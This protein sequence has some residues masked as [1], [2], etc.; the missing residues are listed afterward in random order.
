MKHIKLF[1]DFV[2]EGSVW[3][4]RDGLGINQ[5]SSK[6]I[7]SEIKKIIKAQNTIEGEDGKILT[8][9]DG[10][11]VFFEVPTV[12]EDVASELGGKTVSKITTKDGL[13]NAASSRGGV[14]VII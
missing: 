9:L 12:G 4:T 11:V 14:M 8:D 1:E 3:K 7:N 13:S 10:N 5:I 2:T 6:S